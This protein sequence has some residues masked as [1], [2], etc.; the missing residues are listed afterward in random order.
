LPSLLTFAKPGHVLFGSDW[1]YANTQ[2]VN[3]FTTHLDAY[4][5]LDKAG[6]AAIN[7]KSAETLFPR[8]AS[9]KHA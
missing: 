5:S 9:A 8:L 7:R 6:H 1:P 4:S 2:T 3:F